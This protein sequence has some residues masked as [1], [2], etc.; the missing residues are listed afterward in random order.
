MSGSSEHKARGVPGQALGDGI[1][2]DEAGRLGIGEHEGEAVGGIIGVER[3][4]GGAALHDGE[5]A[6]DQFGRARQREGDDLL[7]AG[8]LRDQ[9]MRKPV[10][11]GVELGVG[12]RDILAYQRG[13]GDRAARPG[14]RSAP[15]KWSAARRAR[16]RSTRPAPCRRS[17][18]SRMSIPPIGRSGS[19]MA[20]SNKRTK[21]AAMAS[22]VFRSNRSV[23][24]SIV[25]S[26]PPD[27]PCV[28]LRSFKIKARS[29]LA[30]P[31]LIGCAAMERP[32]I[33]RLEHARVLERQ[34]HLEQRVAAQRPCRVDSLDDALE[35]QILIRVSVEIGGA[36]AIQQFA[37]AGISGGVGA[38]HHGI[39]EKSDQVVERV[40][41]SSRDRAADRDVRARAKPREQRGEPGLEHHEKAG[42]LLARQHQQT[43]VQF[44]RN[45]EGD[46]IAMMAGNSGPGMIGRQFQL[47]RQAMQRRLPVG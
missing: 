10:G 32:G 28:T 40:I 16:C 30:T 36:H 12:E 9:Q 33:S 41:G 47:L 3:Q 6:D 5:Q 45:L 39:H 7:G 23:L 1:A 19:A 13:G 27:M 35:R 34:H 17:A 26:I 2:G 43:L 37:E 14:P 42:L 4:I 21:R 38:Q 8:A 44:R 20:D 24:Y 11:A 29:N 15:A 31:L 18:A 25:P 22:T 46:S